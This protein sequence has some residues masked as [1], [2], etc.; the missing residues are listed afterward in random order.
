MLSR[1]NR[2]IA[3]PD[4]HHLQCAYGGLRV[5]FHDSL[6]ANLRNPKLHVKVPSLTLSVVF[7]Y[8]VSPV[9]TRRSF[10][11]DTTLFGRQQR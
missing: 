8:I 9:S 7:Y 2:V 6:P 1:A 10:D 5:D 3:R 4:R 11:V